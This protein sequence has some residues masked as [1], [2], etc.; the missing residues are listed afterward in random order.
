MYCN[1]NFPKH[2][3][4]SEEVQTDKK[5]NVTPYEFIIWVLGSF[6]SVKEL[7]ESLKDNYLVGTSFAPSMPITPIHWLISD[8]KDAIVVEQTKEL[9]LVAYDNGGE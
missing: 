3:Y 8:G 9:G 7:K 4:F 2:A 6:S 1:L 5:Y